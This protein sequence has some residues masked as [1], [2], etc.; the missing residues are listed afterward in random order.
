MRIVNGGHACKVQKYITGFYSGVCDA[1]CIGKFCNAV[2]DDMEGLL[3][4]IRVMNN[5]I[6]CNILRK[7]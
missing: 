3:V 1:L 4:M 2:F 5:F 7:A 6:L